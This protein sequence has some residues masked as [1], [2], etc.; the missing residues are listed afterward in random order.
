MRLLSASDGD[1]AERALDRPDAIPPA[2][3]SLRSDRS[4]TS[5]F[6]VAD[7]GRLVWLSANS[8]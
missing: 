3:L 2:R 8:F 7:S 4:R 5:V 1:N 6:S